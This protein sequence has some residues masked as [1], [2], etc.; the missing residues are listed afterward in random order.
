MDQYV[1]YN[2]LQLKLTNFW[3]IFFII[4]YSGLDLPL[5]VIKIKGNGYFCPFGNGFGRVDVEMDIAI[6]HSM[7]NLENMP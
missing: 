2:D 7:T 4:V 3:V 5:L 6:V 1:S